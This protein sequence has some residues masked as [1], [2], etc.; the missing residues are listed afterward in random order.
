MQ[1]PYHC[2]FVR[3]YIYGFG[4]EFLYLVDYVVASREDVKSLYKV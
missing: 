1:R 4:V 2:L 3:K